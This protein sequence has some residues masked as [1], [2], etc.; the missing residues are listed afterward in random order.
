MKSVS[1]RGQRGKD[2]LSPV[3]KYPDIDRNDIRVLLLTA[4]ERKCKV[5]FNAD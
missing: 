4:V 2:D 1:E 5:L 3:G